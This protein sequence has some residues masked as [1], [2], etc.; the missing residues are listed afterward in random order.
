MKLKIFLL[1]GLGVCFSSSISSAATNQNTNDAAYDQAR[2]D[3]RA[4]LQQLKTLSS[5]YKQITG[6]VKKVIQEEGVP[7][8]DDSGMGGIKMA[9]VTVQEL[10]GQTFGDTDIQDTD[11]YLIVKLDIPGVKK[12][13]LKVSILE[14]DVLRVTGRREEEQNN[15]FSSSNARYVRAERRHGTFDRQVKLPV[16]VSNTGTEARYENGVLTV[17]VLKASANTKEIP[18]Q[19]R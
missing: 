11:K 4:Y 5:Q 8:W 1:V 3:Y 9:D 13:E 15:N 18:V 16:P 2:Q 6:E 14:N 17:R 19:I 10:D 12:E 7:V